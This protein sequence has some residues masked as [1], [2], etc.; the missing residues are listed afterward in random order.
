ML[1]FVTI[2]YSINQL[3]DYVELS[4]S[5]MVQEGDHIKLSTVTS[6]EVEENESKLFIETLQQQSKITN[7]T[8]ILREYDENIDTTIFYV[9]GN[10]DY[11]KKL[12]IDQ[13]DNLIEGFNGKLEIHDLREAQAK[14]DV[15]NYYYIFGDTTSMQDTF[16]KLSSTYGWSVTFTNVTGSNY[17]G[18]EIDSSEIV[19]FIGISLLM[20]I[21]NYDLLLK[22]TKKI[23]LS[24]TVGHSCFYLYIK[25]CFKYYILCFFSYLSV[26]AIITILYVPPNYQNCIIFYQYVLVY[27]LISL[28]LNCFFS[29]ILYY[30]VL[31]IK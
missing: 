11:Y 27:I 8:V 22:I 16:K 31:S 29:I 23:A 25:Y 4:L 28:I 18:F 14:F 24:R 2:F 17:N 20:F 30:E 1:V 26:T 15:N 6:L 21:T 12:I 13:N 10:K 5:G 9:S 19:I 7:N 3:T